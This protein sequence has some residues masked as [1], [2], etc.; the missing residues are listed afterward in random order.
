[1][2][3]QVGDA[4]GEQLERG[5]RREPRADKRLVHSVA[6]EWIDEAG[7][8]ADDERAAPCDEAPGGPKRQAE[9]AQAGQPPRVEA[10]RAAEACE[11]LPQR[12]SGASPP[13]DADVRVVALGEDPA[14]AAGHGSELD[15]RAPAVPPRERL[16]VGEVAL[17]RHADLAE[18][19]EAECPGR[20]PVDPVRADEELRAE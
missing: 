15:E 16:V 2:S 8:I 6:G 7:C 19:A 20:D 9:A 11:R 14:V 5:L 1:V 18:P 4:A 10:V 17:E 13:A 3:G 12:R